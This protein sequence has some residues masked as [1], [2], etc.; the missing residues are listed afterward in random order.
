MSPCPPRT[1]ISN[2]IAR[3]WRSSRETRAGTPAGYES[4]APGRLQFRSRDRSAPTIALVES[5]KW[6]SHQPPQVK[7]LSLNRR[8]CDVSA[9]A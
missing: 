6:D 1:S 5:V 7:S 4:T 8:L 2:V 9:F 3:H